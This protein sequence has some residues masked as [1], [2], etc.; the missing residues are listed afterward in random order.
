LLQTSQKG[1]RLPPQL[2]EVVR[3]REMTGKATTPKVI[4]DCKP[5]KKGKG[6]KAK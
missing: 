4:L 6:N 1:K 3:E 2:K 5:Q